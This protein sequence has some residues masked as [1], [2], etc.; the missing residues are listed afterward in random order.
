M[1]DQTENDHEQQHDRPEQ[2]ESLEAEDVRLHGLWDLTMKDKG[3]NGLPHRKTAVLLLA[4]DASIDELGVKDEVKEL[5]GVFKNIYNYTVRT[6]YIKPTPHPQHQVSVFLANFVFEF[7]GK[8]TL[9]IVYYAGH[10]S[11]GNSLPGSPGDLYLR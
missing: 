9:L 6:E 3:G 2:E 1:S 5:E 7:D 10:G 11:P 8:D 4:W